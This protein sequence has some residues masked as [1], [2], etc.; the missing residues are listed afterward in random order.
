VLSRRSLRAIACLVFALGLGAD[1]CADPLQHDVSHLVVE[2]KEEAYEL[3]KE[4]L[5]GKDLE[6]AFAAVAKKCSLDQRTA[7]T[8][9]KVGW[10]GMNGSYDDAFARGALRTRV[11]KMS[12]PIGSGFGW[13]L[14]FVHAKRGSGEPPKSAKRVADVGAKR[15]ASSKK[16]AAVIDRFLAASGGREAHEA[17][18]DRTLRFQNRRE[19]I[20]VAQ[21]T[22]AIALHMTT[23]GKIRE[24]W[25]I[26][27]FQVKGKNL[28]FIQIYDGKAGWV[29]MLGNVTPLVGRTLQVFLESKR[30]LPLFVTWRADGYA[31]R[32]FGE[33]TVAIGAEKTK[34]RTEVVDL[35]GFTGGDNV[36][37]FFS[38][39]T[40]MLVK[41][42]WTDISR[43]PARK[44]ETHYK[45]YA[46]ASFGD[47][48]GRKVLVARRLTIYHDGKL[49]STHT[50][51]EASFNNALA[52][53]FFSKPGG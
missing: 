25:T 40:G 24:E 10:V 41:K 37:L 43:T 9:G 7:K 34:V 47:K 15:R 42:E 13:H 5:R 35:S 22:V 3:R 1:L 44:A 23:D 21:A 16:A 14:I 30:F 29:S 39:E 32:Y 26:E 51:S 17:V 8:G 4:I 50:I 31:L 27:G 48:S 36:R 33:E 11:G 19:G 49:D 53:E 38:K 20:A 2:S 45:N 28:E 6:A 52:D 46:T 18:K 12:G